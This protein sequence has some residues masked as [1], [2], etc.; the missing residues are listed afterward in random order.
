MT[1]KNIGLV[2]SGGGVHAL[3]HAGFLKALI[4]NGIQPTHLSGTSGGTLIA[5]LYATGYQPD[6]ML[7]FFKKTPLFSF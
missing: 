6:E 1:N 3:A 2:L 4:E 5:A 7:A